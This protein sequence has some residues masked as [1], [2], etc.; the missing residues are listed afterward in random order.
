[1][2]STC[3]LEVHR[4]SFTLALTYCDKRH[5][6]PPRPFFLRCPI[7]EELLLLRYPGFIVRYYDWRREHNHLVY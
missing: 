7:M 2:R 4:L 1:M 3:D 5:R 6:S